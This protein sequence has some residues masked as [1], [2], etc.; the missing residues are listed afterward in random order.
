MP[1]A[2]SIEHW[3]T[4]N[5][6]ERN[7][8]N[9]TFTR[10]VRTLHSVVTQRA[11]GGALRDETKNGCEGDYSIWSPS[12][13]RPWVAKTYT[14]NIVVMKLVRTSSNVI[15]SK[16][17]CFRARYHCYCW[18]KLIFSASLVQ[19]VLK[20]FVVTPKKDDFLQM[21]GEAVISSYRLLKI[22]LLFIENIFPFLIG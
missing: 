13:V 17:Y 7:L 18:L 12:A 3:G 8:S 5:A 11:Q 14:K 9:K 4:G 10:L 16:R 20:R 6:W 22:I 21:S 2:F 15:G 1:T 19:D